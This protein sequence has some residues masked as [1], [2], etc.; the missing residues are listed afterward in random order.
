VITGTYG[1]R[2]AYDGPHTAFV[3][4]M[5]SSQFIIQVFAV[6]PS[7]IAGD[8]DLNLGFEKKS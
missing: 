2:P 5:I 1:K 6:A 3:A 8:G 7:V 4:V